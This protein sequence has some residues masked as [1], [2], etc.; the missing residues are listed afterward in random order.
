M[1]GLAAEAGLSAVEVSTA[2]RPTRAASDWILVSADAAFL[3]RAMTRGGVRVGD[4]LRW[5]G[6]TTTTASFAFCAEQFLHKTARILARRSENVRI[7]LIRT[8]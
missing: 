2:R 5:S 7:E 3:D 6:P 8:G 4:S 1:R